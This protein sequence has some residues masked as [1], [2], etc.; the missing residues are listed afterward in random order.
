MATCLYTLTNPNEPDLIR[1]IGVTKQEYQTQRY[2]NH[3]R[4]GNRRISQ[5]ECWIFSLSKQGIKPV[6]VIIRIFDDGQE[7]YKAE[8]AMIAEYRML[9]DNKLTNGQDGGSY[10]VKFTEETKKLMKQRW[11]E[12]VQKGT[13]LVHNRPHSEEA[14]LKMSLIKKGKKAWNKGLPMSEEQKIKLSIA[15][16][17]KLSW[18]AGKRLTE[19]HIESLRRGAQIRRVTKPCTMETRKK[20]SNSIRQWWERRK[21]V[22]A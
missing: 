8:Q 21:E 3:V 22:A 15:N 2:Y 14:K 12:R 10:N 7:A 11:D 18:N 9:P 4:S 19:K 1:Y 17:G 6:M 13:H 20:L 16:K 5:K